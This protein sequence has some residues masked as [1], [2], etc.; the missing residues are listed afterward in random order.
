[1]A[2]QIPSVYGLESIAVD[3]SGAATSLL[4]VTWTAALLRAYVRGYML[5]AVGWDDWTLIP[6]LV[7]NKCPCEECLL[8]IQ[9]AFTTQCAYLL[10]IADAE[11]HPDQHSRPKAI[12]EVVTV[13]THSKGFR[14]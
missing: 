9:V 7:S 13:S 2:D 1:M 3:L 8:T 12:S 4:V 10:K 6:T 5:R 14:Y 11:M